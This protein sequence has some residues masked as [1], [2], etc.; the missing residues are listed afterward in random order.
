MQTSIFDNKKLG[1]ISLVAVAFLA[2]AAA[3]AITLR[4]DMLVILIIGGVVGLVGFI[5]IYKR[6]ALGAALI[7]GLAPLEGVATYSG[8]SAVKLI[9]VLCVGI[10]ILKM[11]FSRKEVVF[12]R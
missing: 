4:I 2:V 3:V 11:I 6:P 9:T 5:A 8:Q 1:I 7:L 12:D 10:F